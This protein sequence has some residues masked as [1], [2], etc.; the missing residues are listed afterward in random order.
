MKKLIVISAMISCLGILSSCGDEGPSSDITVTT[1]P[2]K[3]LI[4]TAGYVVP[5]PDDD[6]VDDSYEVE[7]PWFEFKINIK[8]ET[9][10]YYLVINALEVTVT[11]DQGKEDT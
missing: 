7:A 9:T 2:E 4:V 3:P 5:D 10:D 6:D 1:I 8:N 11:N